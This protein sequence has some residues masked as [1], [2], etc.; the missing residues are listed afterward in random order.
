MF[1]ELSVAKSKASN[2]IKRAMTTRMPSSPLSR[3]KNSLDIWEFTAADEFLNAFRMANGIPVA[4][5]PDLDLPMAELRFD[6][7]DEFQAKR[8]DLVR[9][10]QQ[11]RRD[12]VGTAALGITDAVLLQERTLTDI[13]ATQKWRKGTARDHLAIGLKHFA[14][15][16]GNT[17]RGARDWKYVPKVRAA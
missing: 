5:D 15:L 2:K 12:L 16:R 1:A 8:N 9:V 13:D 14:A 6:A 10:Y 3:L 11:W 17:P 4:R 7:A